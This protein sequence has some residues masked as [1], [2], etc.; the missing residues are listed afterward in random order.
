MTFKQLNELM[1]QQ[2]EAMQK[3]KLFR[4]NITGQEVWDNYLNG[5][6][7]GENPVFRD[8]ESSEANC[9]NDKNFIRRYGNIVAI[10][11]DFRLVSMFDI[12]VTGSKYEHTINK[13]S[14]LIR[15][16]KVSEVFF[17][18]FQELN[19]LP[20]E[21]TNTNKDVF[22]L[23]HDRTLKRYTAEEAKKFGVVNTTD[24]YTFDHFHVFLKKGFVK[25]GNV[26][27]E[28]IMGSYRDAKNVFQRGMEEISLDTL[29]L[30]KDLIS[31]G[32]LLDGQTHLNKVKAFCDLKEDYCK[33]RDNERDD[34]CWVASYDLPIAKFRNELIGTLCVELSEGKEL[35]AACQTWNKRVDP[36]NYMK[37]KAP[38]TQRQIEEAKKFVQENGYE[39][40][41]N[42]RFANIDDI[43]ISEILH[44]NAGNGKVKVVSLFDNVKST[45]TRHKRSEFDKVEEIGIETFMKDILPTCT[46]VEAFFSNDKEGNLVTLTT[47]NIPDSK[48]IFKWDNNYSWSFKGNLAGKS[49]IKE[50][51]KSKGGRVDGVL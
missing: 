11:E 19:V 9:N 23:G 4:V 6:E 47:A 33:V 14:Q 40:S 37:A 8:P 26:S 32:S 20:Y 42:R 3:Y 31:Q 7:P 43:K 16:A 22:Q 10:N 12:N 49:Q 41:F 13:L 34:Y 24:V 45:S 44:A 25:M 35:N 46:S 1:Q 17:E 51:V 2:F 30:V 27:V 48:P 36:A 18:T 38:I 5:F 29:N 21:K 39:E 50:E 15:S 28:S